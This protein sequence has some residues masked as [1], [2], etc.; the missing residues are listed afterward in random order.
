ML[1]KKNTHKNAL[2]RRKIRV[3]FQWRNLNEGGNLED[4]DI[5]SEDNIKMGLK[6]M[7]GSIGFICL[8][9]VLNTVINFCIV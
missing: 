4:L 8:R 5:G 2:A 1:C 6:E 7:E 9:G 3:G